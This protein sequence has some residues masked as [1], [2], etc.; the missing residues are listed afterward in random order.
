V[1]KL[2][3]QNFQYCQT[4]KNC[5]ELTN[6]NLLIYIYILNTNTNNILRYVEGKVFKDGLLPARIFEMTNIEEL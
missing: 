6:K 2:I 1:E 3:F 4:L 5:N